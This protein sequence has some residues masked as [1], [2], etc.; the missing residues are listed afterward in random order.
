MKWCNFQPTHKRVGDENEIK[1]K[2]D[3]YIFSQEHVAEISQNDAFSL[4]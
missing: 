3:W 4:G 1:I 2:S